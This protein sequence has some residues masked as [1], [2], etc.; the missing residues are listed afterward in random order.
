MEGSEKPEW[1]R[2]DT[3]PCRGPTSDLLFEVLTKQ[4]SLKELIEALIEEWECLKKDK[5][6]GKSEFFSKITDFL[7][8]VSFAELEKIPYETLTSLVEMMEELAMIRW[9]EIDENAMNYILGVEE[10][11]HSSIARVWL[12]KHPLLSRVN[13]KELR[14]AI[15]SLLRYENSWADVITALVG[16]IHQLRAFLREIADYEFPQLK[17][18][19]EA[20]E[21][22]LL[23]QQ[24]LV[25]WLDLLSKPSSRRDRLIEDFE[26]LETHI[27][28][29]PYDLDRVIMYFEWLKVDKQKLLVIQIVEE[30][31]TEFRRGRPEE[32][33]VYLWNNGGPFINMW[34]QR[35]E[36]DIG[37]WIYIIEWSSLPEF[38]EVLDQILF[39]ASK[40]EL[41]SKLKTEL[42]KVEEDLLNLIGQI[43]I[44]GEIPYTPVFNYFVEWFDRLG[45]DFEVYKWSMRWLVNSFLDRLKIPELPQECKEGWKHNQW[46]TLNKCEDALRDMLNSL[47]PS[48]K[49]FSLSLEELEAFGKF[50]V[51][52]EGKWS[53]FIMGIDFV[54]KIL[55]DTLQ[56]IFEFFETHP[57]LLRESMDEARKIMSLL[58]LIRWVLMGNEED[59]EVLKQR[60]SK[61][62]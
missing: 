7:A 2:W 8:I 23:S 30:F 40:V 25:N 41:P 53:V 37:S 21:K 20:F 29:I 52:L 13:Q 58:R 44:P 32:K 3:A 45:L 15:K 47:G 39:L 18:L 36:S 56:Y 59:F 14:D 24:A 11:L 43:S 19:E 46:S 51:W 34:L 35:D 33:I 9:K 54:N 5:E 48:N 10:S 60:I 4:G 62:Y 6:T 42:R 27:L 1:W 22:L 50:L 26:W 16:Q 57:K 12:Q 17:H 31:I 55:T 61:T 28:M 49:L 38:F